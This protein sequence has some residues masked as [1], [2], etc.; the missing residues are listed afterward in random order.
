MKSST[1]LLGEMRQIVALLE[2][3]KACEAEAILSGM[4]GDAARMRKGLAQVTH[5]LHEGLQNLPVR[6]TLSR[7]ASHDLADAGS[8]LDHVVH[9]TER[10]ANVTLDLV[11]E[12]RQ[13]LSEGAMPAGQVRLREILNEM[14]EAQ[15]FQDLSGQ[16][17]KRVAALLKQTE[18][19]LTQLLGDAPAP[20]ELVSSSAAGPELGTR[21]PGLDKAADQS[22]A[23]SLLSGLGI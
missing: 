19:A 9:M 6:G 17:I 3:G 15:A 2:A 20:A 22:E 13:L 18:D 21:V 12:A 10:A 11:D 7:L 14:T 8:R 23:D 16:I 4:Y 1:D 5:V